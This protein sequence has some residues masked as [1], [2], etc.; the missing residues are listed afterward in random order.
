MAPN[1]KKKAQHSEQ[2]ATTSRSAK[3]CDKV[4]QVKEEAAPAAAAE[5]EGD[6]ML[7]RMRASKWCMTWTAWRCG[8][9]LL[10]LLFVLPEI[11]WG[12]P[13]CLSA[14]PNAFFSLS[15]SHKITLSSALAISLCWNS[16]SEREFIRFELVLSILIFAHSQRRC[17]CT[18][19]CPFPTLPLANWA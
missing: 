14:C 3:K 9:S 19:H 2:P 7:Q 17:R 12:F 13:S 10:L 6:A 15:L 1:S 11:C 18:P 4:R 8:C 5:V 16:L